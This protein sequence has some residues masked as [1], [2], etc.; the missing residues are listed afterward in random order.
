[1]MKVP[2]TQGA[3][4]QTARIDEFGVYGPGG[5]ELYVIDIPD[6]LMVIPRKK[7]DGRQPV[8]LTLPGGRSDQPMLTSRDYSVVMPMC[9][10]LFGW[11]VTL[12][13]QYLH[14]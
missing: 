6:E 2:T 3:R 7:G 5:H 9:Y 8:R 11:F 10:M 4:P 13:S 14:Q 1:M 12:M